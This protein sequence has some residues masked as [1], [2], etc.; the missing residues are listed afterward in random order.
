MSSASHYWPLSNVDN[1]RISGTIDGRAFGSIEVIS[2]VKDEPESALQFS[3]SGMYIDIPFESEDCLTFPDTCPS[4]Q[5][6]LSFMASFDALAANWDNVVILD[7][8]GGNENNSTGISVTVSKKML[9][10]LVS[11]VDKF[12][13][14]SIP[15]QS[16]TMWHHYLLTCSDSR[17]QIYV[18]GKGVA[19]RLV[20]QLS[21]QC[22]LADFKHGK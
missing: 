20:L 6:T 10:F 7:S 5:L 17:I 2:G 21:L 1:K 14:I 9:V 3:K 12:W 13:K 8:F 4:N 11:Y 22:Y 16:Y 18:N 19:L 15:I